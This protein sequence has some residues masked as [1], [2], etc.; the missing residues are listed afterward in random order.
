MNINPFIN[1]IASIIALYKWVLVAWIISSWLI[2]FNIIN[3]YQPA[4]QK[5]LYVLNRL[6]APVL[7]TIRKFIPP[8]GGIDLSAIILFLLLGFLRDALY[9]YLYKSPVF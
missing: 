2:A 4:V 9:Q 8:I 3:T 5:V 7:D 1:L 6:T